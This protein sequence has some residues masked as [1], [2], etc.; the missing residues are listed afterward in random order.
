MRLLRTHGSQKEDWLPV[1]CESRGQIYA[2]LSHC[3]LPNPNHEVLFRDIETIDDRDEQADASNTEDLDDIDL[4]R[5]PAYIGRP[6]FRKPGY[7]KLRGAAQTAHRHG[8]RFL[9]VDTCCIDK[10]SSAELTEAI[11]SMWQYY[12]QAAHCYAYLEDVVA[13]KLDQ[14]P[15]RARA[16]MP[17]PARA[18]VLTQSHPFAVFMKDGWWN[19]QPFPPADRE[20][21]ISIEAQFRTSR[22]FKRGWTLQELL[23]PSLVKFYD[24]SWTPLCD[25][26][27]QWPL[28][29]DITGISKD[30]LLEPANLANSCIAQKMS[31]ASKRS[32]TRPEDAAYCLLGLFDVAMPMLYG[33]GKKAFLRLQHE[34]IKQSDDRT[35]FAWRDMDN[36]TSS[37]IL[38][39]H[40]SMFSLSGNVRRL[41]YK[42]S[43][44]TGSD[45]PYHMTNKGLSI[46]LPLVKCHSKALLTDHFA[47]VVACDGQNARK[48]VS[49]LLLNT[50]KGYF[51]RV[52]PDRFASPQ[53][54][55]GHHNIDT[56][57][58][59][60]SS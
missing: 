60:S 19:L 41:A 28:I 27:V 11:N 59:V 16:Y 56:S 20:R 36:I 34:I 54:Q 22:W 51:V 31:W 6:P 57:I 50:G 14:T 25:K 39:S 40:P 53:D 23:A 8:Y 35:I 43:S 29:A 15:A 45:Q 49:I 44:G 5:N 33:E 24:R 30:V 55:E 42:V 48:L 9:W 38:A 13:E 32:T 1:L 46:C 58:I 17:D 4:I 52:L 12:S 21:L 7:H 10:S 18:Q 37:G 3:W 2:I 47:A 26:D